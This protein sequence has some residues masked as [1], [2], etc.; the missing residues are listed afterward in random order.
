MCPQLS[1]FLLKAHL[2]RKVTKVNVALFEIFFFFGSKLL[3]VQ[4]P[5]ARLFHGPPSWLLA[6][7]HANIED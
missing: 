1:A 5:L 2:Y 4:T 7:P 3:S 6:A